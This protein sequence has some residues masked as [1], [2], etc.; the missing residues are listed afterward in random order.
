[1]PQSSQSFNGQ[2]FSARLGIDGGAGEC[3]SHGSGRDACGAKIVGER[4]AFLGK[5]FAHEGKKAGL[6]ERQLLKRG[7][8]RQRKTVEWTS[9]GGEKDSAGA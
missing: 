6:I 7:A 9:G 8:K 4:L 3:G 5:D 2:G 1:V